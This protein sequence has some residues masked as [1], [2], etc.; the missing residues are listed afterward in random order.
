MWVRNIFI[1]ALRLKSFFIGKPPEAKDSGNDFGRF[2]VSFFEGWI[3][4]MV[5]S[6]QLCTAAAFWILAL[7]IS[8][9]ISL[10]F[11]GCRMAGYLLSS[12]VLCG[13]T[14]PV[15]L[16]GPPILSSVPVNRLKDPATHS[17]LALQ[18]HGWPL[19]PPPPVGP[20]YKRI[21]DQL[22]GEM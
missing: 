14:K 9:S 4:Y 8:R 3:P 16:S 17:I 13:V 21:M 18:H 6:A 19:I 20:R 15:E 1:W 10:F 5:T 22:G 2:S 7:Q 12:R 11:L